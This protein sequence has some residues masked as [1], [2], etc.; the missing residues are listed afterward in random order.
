MTM[1]HGRYHWLRA[2][3]QVLVRTLKQKRP[4]LS[5]YDYDYDY[6]YYHY[7]YYYYYFPF[8]FSRRY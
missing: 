8:L 2:L 6:Y 1:H 7:Y 5:Y 4:L 3:Y